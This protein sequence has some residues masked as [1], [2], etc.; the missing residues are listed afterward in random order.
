MSDNNKNSVHAVSP[1]LGERRRQ[2]DR[3]SGGDRRDGRQAIE[4]WTGPRWADQ[5]LQFLT[6]YLLG[7]LGLLYFNS[8]FTHPIL[9]MSLVQMNVFIGG[10]LAWVTLELALTLGRP[11]SWAVVRLAMWTDVAALSVAVLHDPS[12]VPL[13]SLIYVIIVLGNGLRYGI[14]W[15][16]EALAAVVLGAGVTLVIRYWGDAASVPPEVIF[17]NL[18]GAIIIFYA[19]VLMERVDASR[20]ALERSSR[21]DALTGLLNRSALMEVSERLLAGV[22]RGDGRLVAIFADL[23]KFKA[24]N[25]THGH[26]EGDRVLTEVARLL[27]SAIRA[28]DVAARY[29][30]DEFVLLLRDLSLDQAEVVGRRIQAEARDWATASGIDISVS[31]GLGEAPTHGADLDALLDRVDQAM[32]QSK[33]AHGAGGLCRA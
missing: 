17:L 22:R 2:D 32:Y 21:E 1:R 20:R 3:R 13:T 7:V 10:Y 18:F 25:D 30:G 27:R 5:R 6:R 4:P 11:H 8:V 29:G 23:D 14:R 12:I 19:Y 33:L 15:F 24:V 31:I 28:G 9:G 26:A 16:A